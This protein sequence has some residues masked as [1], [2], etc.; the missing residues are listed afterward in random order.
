M[1]LFNLLRSCQSLFQSSRTI[2]TFPPVIHQGSDFSASSQT[3]MVHLLYCSHPS[4]VKWYLLIM[5]V[6]ISLKTNDTEHLFM[7]LLAIL[8]VI[9]GEMSIQIFCPF[10]IGLFFLLLLSHES[11][12][13]I[14]FTNPFSDTWF[15]SIFPILWVVFSPS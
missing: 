1:T 10:L 5:L 6:F 14:L 2:L 3:Y 11:S 12:L 15:A 7:C 4:G 13:Y 8:Y 9:F